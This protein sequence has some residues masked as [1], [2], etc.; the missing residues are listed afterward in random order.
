MAIKLFDFGTYTDK[1]KRL[2][3]GR[4]WMNYCIYSKPVD[5]NSQLVIFR[6]YLGPFLKSVTID[7]Y[8]KAFEQ[9]EQSIHFYSGHDATIAT[10]MIT[11]GIYDYILPPYG[12]ALIFELR[13]KPT[14]F[15]VTVSY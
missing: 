10:I 3:S 13:E 11:L 7:M 8:K 6:H 1:M 15:F 5:F 4:Y 14:D 9:L 12:S 2:K